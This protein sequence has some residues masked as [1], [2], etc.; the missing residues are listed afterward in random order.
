[1]AY[2]NKKTKDAYNRL[3]YD[4]RAEELRAKRRARYRARVLQ[5]AVGQ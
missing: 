3:Y 4:A 1:M 5:K 2:R